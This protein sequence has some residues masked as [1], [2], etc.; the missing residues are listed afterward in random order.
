[1]AKA[2]IHITLS[3]REKKNKGY[4][5]HNHFVTLPDS[6]PKLPQLIN[7]IDLKQLLK[8]CAANKRDSQKQL[9]A[10]FYG[11]LMSICMRYA[12]SNDDAV[13]ILNDGFL[14]IFREIGKFNSIHNSITADFK[15]WIKR[16]V[17][18]TAIDHYRKYDKHNHHAEITDAQLDTI[19]AD[20]S[21]LAK[22]SY[23][24]IIDCVQQLS[25][26]Y[27]TVFSLFVLDGFSHEEIGEQLGIAIGTSKSNLS[28]AR[29]HLQKM[30]HAKN[31][32]VMYER[33]AV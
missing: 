33:R 16:I 9:Y 18:Y 30:L 32:Y 27:R 21:Q 13:E 14:K 15:G 28:K 1:L 20:E 26:A 8:D 17:I 5:S 2:V 4:T 31:N 7:N 25:P 3:N 24:E 19:D 10:M 23:K 29:Q 6:R 11:Y 12:K 22:I